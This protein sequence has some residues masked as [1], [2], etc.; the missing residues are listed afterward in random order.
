MSHDQILEGKAKKKLLPDK[1]FADRAK[2]WPMTNFWQ[3]KQKNLLPDKFFADRAKNLVNDQFLAEKAKFW[4][5]D[6]NFE[7]KKSKNHMDGALM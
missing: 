3:E 4:S 2:I 7:E 6:E 5:H 1:F